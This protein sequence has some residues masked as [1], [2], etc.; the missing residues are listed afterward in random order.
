MR[1][2]I[3]KPSPKPCSP[4]GEVCPQRSNSWKSLMRCSSAMPG[5]VSQTP[6]RIC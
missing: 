4:Q 6:I 5:P 3:A 1:C 2:T